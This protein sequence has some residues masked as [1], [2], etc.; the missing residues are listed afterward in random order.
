VRAVIAD[1][2]PI[3]HLVLIGHIEIL[4]ALFARVIFPTAVRDELMHDE[5]PDAVRDW[6]GL[7][8]AWL[9]VRA[10]P[11]ASPLGD[12]S[13]EALDEGEKPALVL[14]DSLPADLLLMDDRDG[15]R[16][17]RRLGFRV[18]GSLSVLA[19][20]ARRGLLDLDDAFERIKRTNFR[21]R[22]EIMDRLR[23]DRRLM[24]AY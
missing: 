6:I 14:A 20:G 18:I 16:V 12:A 3:Q 1:T 9:E 7:S 19:W 10:A 8:P 11:A 13:S 22:E 2:G 15:V 4:P 5:A 24:E 21:Y 17:G 23:D